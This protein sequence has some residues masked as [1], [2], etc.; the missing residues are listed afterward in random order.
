M[1]STPRAAG[2]TSSVSAERPWAPDDVLTPQ[3]LAERLQLSVATVDRMDLPTIYCGQ[4]RKRARRF[5]WGQV[6]RALEARAA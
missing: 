4:G 5:V 6:I 3:Q 2:Y 1:T